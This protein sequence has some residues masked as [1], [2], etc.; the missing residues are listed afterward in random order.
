MALGTLSPLSRR[1]LAGGLARDDDDPLA[2]AALVATAHRRLT[3]HL[4]TFG[5]ALEVGQGV[6]G[7]ALEARLA[8]LARAETEYARVLERAGLEDLALSRAMGG[9]P[10]AGCVL[11]WRHLVLVGLADVPPPMRAQL[12]VVA[13]TNHLVT[14]LIFAPASYADRFDDCGGVVRSAWENA[15]LDLG[16]AQI[17]VV[18]TPEDLIDEALGTVG[19]LPA[20]TKVGDVVLGVAD[21]ALMPKMV[22][23][24]RRCGLALRP[25]TAGE[26]ARTPTALLLESVAEL[27]REGTFR[28]WGTLLRHPWFEQAL[29]SWLNSEAPAATTAEDWLEKLDHYVLEH[30]PTTLSRGFVEDAH[31]DTLERVLDATVAALGPLAPRM[32]RKGASATQS[33]SRWAI[34]IGEFL[35]RV[36]PVPAEEDSAARTEAEAFE[37][38]LGMMRALAQTPLLDKITSA[39][40]AVSMAL[41]LAGEAPLPPREVDGA[42]EAVGWLE[43]ALDPA[44]HVVIAGLGEGLV[45]AREPSDPL[46]PVA[47]LRAAGIEAAPSRLARDAYVLSQLAHSRHTLAIHLSRVGADGEPSLPSRLLFL[48]DE[49]TLRARARLWTKSKEG[50]P[51][52][53]S[54]PPQRAA[55]PNS[56]FEALPVPR[57]DVPKTWR[58]TAFKDYLASP[59]HFYLR[60]IAR[61]AEVEEVGPELLPHR[62]GTLI[63][64]VLR[65]FGGSSDRELSTEESLRAALRDRFESHLEAAFGSAMSAPLWIQSRQALARLDGLARWQAR[66]VG[67]GWAIAHVEW[68]P[69]AGGVA[70]AWSGGEVQLT[71]RI[72]RVDV[73]PAQGVALIDYKLF[74]TAKTPEKTHRTKESW[75]D[76]QL[77]LYRHLAK[78]LLQGSTPG[79]TLAYVTLAGDGKADIHAASWDDAALK[80]ADA[81]ARDVIAAVHAGKFRDEGRSPTMSPIF[82]ALAGLGHIQE[83][84]G[85][86][87]DA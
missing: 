14:S 48:A 11:A 19:R 15:H 3:S 71:G 34:V 83:I 42:V 35:Q 66:R 41:D 56:A 59:Y 26:I 62:F 51:A 30:L 86:E 24:G 54:R 65:D 28:E 37:S 6:H 57:I 64:A 20:G 79:P 32:T 69:Q 2:L 25:A 8:A 77:P 58:V 78:A 22:R 33:L 47:L 1:D 18:D 39:E 21:A 73:H 13:R 80:S 55:R 46:L 43:L 23:R 72:D 75:I 82:A 76:L 49:A 27:L 68:T 7:G 29:L 31:A 44:P 16:S 40:A 87:D 61:V 53:I 38:A 81:A 5:R 84:E 9:E 50:A 12:E 4:V 60:H 17:T 10:G 45:P 52:A 74:D 63:H 85:K 67:E 70:F 36:A